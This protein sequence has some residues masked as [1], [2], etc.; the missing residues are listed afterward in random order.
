MGQHVSLQLVRTIELLHTPG[1]ASERALEP[2]DGIMDQ[3]VTFQLVPAIKGSRTDV[4]DVRFDPGVDDQV[5]FEVVGRLEGLVTVVALVQPGPVCDQVTAEVSLTG[6]HLVTLGT[7]VVVGTGG[8]VV[9]QSSRGRVLVQALLA[10]VV[11]LTGP[12]LVAPGAVTVA[13]GTGVQ[14]VLTMLVTGQLVQ[15]DK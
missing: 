14:A 6:E 8:Q 5:N 3:F 2:F 13:V 11:P 7:G 10:P 1:V 12:G 4:A 9:F 15:A